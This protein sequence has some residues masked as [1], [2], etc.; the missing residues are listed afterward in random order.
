M[1][2]LRVLV[3]AILIAVSTV[4]TGLGSRSAYALTY[5]DVGAWQTSDNTLPAVVRASGSTVY[6]NYVYVVGGD[7]ADGPTNAVSYAHLN[8]DGTTST[9]Q[10]TTVLP[11]SF[12][13]PTVVAYNGYIYVMGGYG[14]SPSVRATIYYAQIDA[15]NGSLG[16][17]T[18]SSTA[19]PYA[20]HAATG[21]VHN[22]YLYYMGG[23]NVG[24]TYSTVSYATINN[25]GSLGSWTSSTP[26]PDS[27]RRASTFL[28]NDRVYVLGGQD[29]SNSIWNTVMY[30]DLN[31]NGTVGS[32]TVSDN[33]LPQQR[34]A[35][36]AAYI[37]GF[38]YYLAGNSGSAT[39]A[40]VYH[41]KVNSDGTTDTW[42][43]ATNSLPVA[44]DATMAVSN[45][46]Y[47]YVVGG[48]NGSGDK[49]DTVYYAQVT[50]YDANGDDDSDGVTN[51]VEDAAPN[52][53]DANSD[54]IADSEQPSVASFVSS[55]TAHYVTV[56]MENDGPVCD[57]TSVDI[58]PESENSTQDTGYAYNLGMLN[59]TAT[60]P[61]DGF[62]V[63]VR[64]MYFNEEYN[65]DFVL[66]KYNP[67][68]NEYA[69]VG[70]DNYPYIYLYTADDDTSVLTAS[71]YIE[72]GG[73]LDSDGLANSTIV[74]PVGLGVVSAQSN[75]IDNQ[76]ST[77]NS[78]VASDS[79][80]QT[81]NN[82][83]LYLFASAMLVSSGIGM[84][85]RSRRSTK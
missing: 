53:G 33:S 57:I 65:E 62:G 71:Y 23:V 47:L 52:S 44:M 27:R 1:H 28:V 17:W 73:A 60:C 8:N 4:F 58:S 30:A 75:N 43:A 37:N 32:W 31:S 77:N 64:I 20:S 10:S 63:G 54:G 70:E 6:N 7:G 21:V 81:G 84:T 72:D 83:L 13:E 55:V 78:S 49:L 3:L 67:S 46:N 80:A 19:L 2:R 22:G 14:G 40:T 56:V 42:S 68:S 25:D 50:P 59:F 76:G 38:A 79:L 66:R 39:S 15:D 29:I 51:G 24:S 41:A 74:D 69:E 11:D 9:W 16:S 5:G 36:G 35:G 34:L 82:S 85:V 18:T 48:A 61:S 12:M 45:G 26:M